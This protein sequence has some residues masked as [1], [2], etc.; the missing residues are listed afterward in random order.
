MLVVMRPTVLLDV[1]GTL[2]DSYPGIREGFL[3]GLDAVGWQRPDEEFIRRIPG[4][5]MTETMASLG[6]DEATVAA[7]MGAYSAYMSDEGWCKFSVFAGMDELVARWKEQGYRVVTA[8]SKGE[9]F[10]R[11]A[12]KRA[13]ILDNIDFLGAAQENGPRK[14]KIDVLAHVLDVLGDSVGPGSALM[15][16]DRFHDFEAASHFGIDSV[17]VAWGYADPQEYCL[18]THVAHTPEELEDI[19]RDNCTC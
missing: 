13:G 10:A 3:R 4:P 15:I 8:T 12:L 2:I 19:V 16:G 18:A 11:A 1:D 5:P 17:A 14:K 6:M 9:G 7:A